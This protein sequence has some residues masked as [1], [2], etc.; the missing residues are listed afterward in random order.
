MAVSSETA[1]AAPPLGWLPLVIVVIASVETWLALDDFPGALDLHGALLS[2]GQ[3][4]INARLAVHPVFLSRRFVL[5][6]AVRV[7][8]AIIVLA[9]FILLAWLSEVPSFVR[10]GIE[11]NWTVVGLPLFA[12]QAVFPALA[13]AAIAL[14]QRNKRLWLATLFVALPPANLILG[15]IVFAIGIAIY[16]F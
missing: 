9:V 7:R 15:V 2:F 11:W 3:F 13:V 16:G 5:A 12:Q 8:A 14:A 1:V 10:F 6:V 4:L